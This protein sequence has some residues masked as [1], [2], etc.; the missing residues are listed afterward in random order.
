MALLIMILKFHAGVWL[1]DIKEGTFHQ[2]KK[3]SNQLASL[4]E[5]E[6]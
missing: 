1:E 3:K 6:L 4:E 5:V 2:K